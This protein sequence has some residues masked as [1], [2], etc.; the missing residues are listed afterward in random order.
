M[1]LGLSDS[2]C[3][4]AGHGHGCT[5]ATALPERPCW[6]QLWGLFG[7][8]SVAATDSCEKG[9]VRFHVDRGN[10]GL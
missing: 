2:D 10:L 9:T 3:D 8:L 6:R 5:G 7:A 1:S 4:V